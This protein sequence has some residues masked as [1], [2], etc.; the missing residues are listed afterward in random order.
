MLYAF[1]LIFEMCIY[2]LIF[3]IVEYFE[4]PV[5]LDVLIPFVIRV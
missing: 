4:Q 1:L 5:A 2:M 3:T